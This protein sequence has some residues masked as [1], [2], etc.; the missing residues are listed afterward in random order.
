[1]NKLLGILVTPL[2]LAI[3]AMAALLGTQT[4][5]R[6]LL[7]RPQLSQIG[8]HIATVDGHFLDRLVLGEVDVKTTTVTAQAEHLVLDWSPVA[9][10][11]GHVHIRELSVD[12]LLYRAQSAPPSTDTESF[13]IP[14]V[15]VT[16]QLDRLALTRLEL[17]TGGGSPI[18]IDALHASLTLAGQT[19]SW[20][21]L[22]LQA[23][24]GTFS[25]TG[26]LKLQETLPIN[27]LLDWQLTPPAQPL[28]QGSLNAD[29]ALLANLQ[30]ALTTRTPLTSQHQ[31]TLSHLTDQ[32]AFTLDSRWSAANWPVGAQTLNLDP[33]TLT[34]NGTLAAY[35]L[36]LEGAWQLPGTPKVIAKLSGAGDKNQF[37][38][39]DAHLITERSQV[40]LSGAVN[41]QPTLTYQLNLTGQRLRPQDWQTPVTGDI[42]LTLTSHGQWHD[43]G[44]NANVHLPRLQGTLNGYA[45]S[46]QANLTVSP[47]LVDITQLSLRSG[48]NSLSVHG[49]ITAQHGQLNA[50]LQAPKLAQLLP[51]AEGQMRGQLN[52][53]GAWSAPQ[54]T[55]QFDAKALHF[56]NLTLKTLTLNAQLT[57]AQHGQLQLDAKALTLP[58]L[59]LDRLQLNG[60]GHL[61]DHQITLIGQGPELA[62][63]VALQGGWAKQQW[64]GT[65]QQLTGHWQSK[66]RWQLPE[67][68]TL[69]LG[70]NA[71]EP[72]S[73]CLNVN[74]H[75]VCWQSAGTWPKRLQL[76]VRSD[77]LALA[78]FKPWLPENLQL[79]GSA[80]T[81]L[82]LDWRKQLQSATLTATTEGL[83]LY[84][85]DAD[86]S[87]IYPV[88]ILSFNADYRPERLVAAL[89]VN[90][91]NNHL[92]ADATITQ[93]LAQA[94]LD[95]QLHLDWQ[96]FS[97][98]A[99]LTPAV[100]LGEGRVNATI[101]AQG[102]LTQPTLTGQTHLELTKLMLPATGTPWENIKLSAH[103][104]ADQTVHVQ[105]QL[106]S[107]PGQLKLT[108]QLHPAQP[109]WQGQFTLS[110]QNF[111][112]VRLPEAEVQLS[113]A[114]R[115]TVT[116][117]QSHVNGQIKV[118]KSRIA[119][120][121]LPEQ[122]IQP[123]ADEIIM[124]VDHPQS[125]TAPSPPEV[126]L[127]IDVLLG[128]DSQ[129]DGYGLTGQLNGQL[130]ISG[131][132]QQPQVHG[133]VTIKDGRYQAYGQDLAIRQGD[134]LF[135]GPATRP[136]LNIEVARKAAY[137]DITAL[138]RVTGPADA[139]QTT[140]S[141]QPALPESEALAYLITGR[142]L[143]RATGE[144][145]QNLAQ[146][147]LKLGLGQL[148][149]VGAQAGL[150]EL[151]L[152]EAEQL[153]NTALKLGK[154]ITPDL[155]VGATLGFFS[156][157]YELLLQQQLTKHLSL[158]SQIGRSQR[159]EVQYQLDTD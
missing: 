102:L 126:N 79:E 157:A 93:P 123:S 151:S 10:L 35:R 48:D 138:L 111:T 26:Q 1:M 39:T 137:A 12:G 25:S 148:N 146:A 31:L 156:N 73:G 87:L 119:L 30:L 6:W 143:E 74:A 19:L 78:Q 37:Q 104:D 5:T 88:Q 36:A 45:L 94:T 60:Q 109:H 155:Y 96:D 127:N 58:S 20:Q 2:L 63:D 95:S 144:Q 122:A 64:Q 84:L 8:L 99:K 75:P 28:W 53:D 29:G 105:G 115:M 21:P 69:T 7:S 106:D 103:A 136:W 72:G 125:K 142:S 92:S 80:S 153:E 57:P 81:T 124:G 90:A 54:I 149:W 145:G 154:Y 13:S 71:V 42:N 76:T 77:H 44:L 110:G 18:I 152:T 147:A 22:T 51:D 24:N 121:K 129:F 66:A 158:N 89:R 41:W 101:Q 65:L 159:L 100:I 108:G 27:A 9:L 3:L 38:L 55:A 23:L 114:L 50:Q 135:N 4:G 16:L 85:N 46:G 86:D 43:D 91:Q 34:L 113:P 140:V 17:D 150:D 40:N 47:N 107:K 82:T 33:G 118:A 32:P 134:F 128:E 83:K 62:L 139:P 132:A 130:N 98:L 97:I 61:T 52:I 133:K 15:P 67:P 56:A 70:N 116:A 131:Q 11:H 141:S 112:A 59:Q 49:Q 120:E 68:V 14:H 117:Q